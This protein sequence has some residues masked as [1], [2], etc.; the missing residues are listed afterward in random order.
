MTFNAPSSHNES[1][2]RDLEDQDMG[3]QMLVGSIVESSGLTNFGNM[4]GHQRKRS[5]HRRSNYSINPQKF[6]IGGVDDKYDF[7]QLREKEE[8][9]EDEDDEASENY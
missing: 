4:S 7:Y 2:E 6:S 8:P 5:H 3:S 1:E 9:E